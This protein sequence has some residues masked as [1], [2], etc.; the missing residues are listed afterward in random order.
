MTGTTTQVMLDV[1]DMM[2]GIPREARAAT[3]ERMKKMSASIASFATGCGAAALLFA[4]VREWCFLVPCVVAFTAC[5]LAPAEDD[6]G[7]RDR[8]HAP[9]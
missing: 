9:G 1:A 4:L 6:A 7:A 2:R 8:A 5:C 3:V